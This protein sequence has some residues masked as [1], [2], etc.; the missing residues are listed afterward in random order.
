MS[1]PDVG[2][3]ELRDL[4]QQHPWFN[5]EGVLDAQSLGRWIGKLGDNHSN[6][7]KVVGGVKRVVNPTHPK[8]ACDELL[9]SDLDGSMGILLAQ[10]DADEEQ[11]C[12]S[13]LRKYEDLELP[14]W[15]VQ[16]DVQGNIMVGVQHHSNLVVTVL[17]HGLT[18]PFSPQLFSAEAQLSVGEVKSS[19]SGF[20]DGVVQLVRRLALMQWTVKQ[21]RPA[22]KE[23]FKVGLNISSSSRGAPSPT[24]NY[25]CC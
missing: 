12:T 13:E 23:F 11:Y 3:V 5:E 10:F 14:S 2:L 25:S 18:V 17:I 7:R 24:D 21:L 1:T 4:L 16:C 22:I 15:R 20:G 19:S 8:T 9:A 6:L